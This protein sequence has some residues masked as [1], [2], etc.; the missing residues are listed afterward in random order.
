[1][2][3]AQSIKPLA[4]KVIAL[5]KHEPG[6][7][8]VWLEESE[9]RQRVVKRFETSPVKQALLA[10]LRIHPGQ[11]ERR[12]HTRLAAMG[13]PVVGIEALIWQGGRCCL[14]SAYVGPS[15]DRVIKAGDCAH[16]S[17]RHHIAR[18]LGH[19][20]G[21]L[22][23]RGL[24]FRDLKLSNLL[25]ADDGNL[26]I[27]DAGSTRPVNGVARSGCTLRMMRLLEKTAVQALA[28]AP[29]ASLMSRADRLRYALG[30][31]E[32]CTGGLAVVMLQA[33]GLP[34]PPRCLGSR[35]DSPV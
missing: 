8:M 30:L 26:Q 24:F 31:L 18:Q 22:V 15:L 23:A 17:T 9:G 21:M 4:G 13:L 35:L 20:T 10:M 27:I 6:R 5:Y 28:E 29:V 14:T 7:S 12:M 34:R 11:C 19:V 33:M 3:D 32:H 25:L 1:M 2:V 16:P